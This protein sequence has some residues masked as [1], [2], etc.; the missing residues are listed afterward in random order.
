MENNMPTGL[1]S[2][3]KKLALRRTIQAIVAGGTLSIAAA[4]S[5]TAIDDTIKK[6]TKVGATA[7]T[8]STPSVFN[9]DIRTVSKAPKWQPGDAIKVVNP[10]R[11]RNTPNILPPVNAPQADPLVA[12]QAQ[13]KVDKTV[14]RSATVKVNMDGLGFSGVNPPDPTGDIGLNYYIQSING[15]SGALFSIHDK[16]DGS[17]VADSLSMSDLHTGDCTSTS[18]DPIVL[19]DEQANRWLL[20]EFANQG[21]D[22][23]CVLVSQTDDPVNGGWYAY[24]FQAPSFPDYPKYSQIGGVYYASANENANAVYAFDREKMLVGERTTMVRMEI[25]RLSGFGF[26]SIT[27]IDVD[28]NMPAPAGTPGMFIRHRD[29]ELHNSGSNNPEKDYLEIYTL[30]P[31][32]ESP[33]DSVLIGPTSI[34]VAEF[35]SDFNCAGPGFGCLTQKDSNYTL[36]PLRETVMYKGQYRNF[37]GHESIVGNF[38]TNPGDNVAA[39]RWFELRRVGESDWALHDEGTYSENDGTSRYMGGAVLDKNGNLGLSYM[40]TGADR[41]P[42]IGFNGREASDAAGTLTFGE[43]IL[44][45]GTSS[46]ESDR[47]GDYSQMGIDPVDHCTMWFT[48]EYGKESGV[49]GT[50]IS[51]F[52][53]PSCADPNPG[54][55]IALSDSAQEVCQNGD[56]APMTVSASAYND[57]DDNIMLS[58]SELPEGF[59]GSFSANTFKPGEMVTT[60]VTIA[61]GTAAGRYTFNIDAASGDATP[62]SSSASVNIVGAAATVG[63]SYPENGAEMTSVVPEFSWET[64]GAAKTVKIEIATD[65]EFS[66]IVAMGEVSGGNSYRPSTPLASATQFYWRA[67]AINVCGDTMSEVYSFMTDDETSYATELYNQET[68]APLTL[69]AQEITYYF[70][71]VLPG[72]TDLTISTQGDNG[73]ADLYVSYGAR[74]Q[75]GVSAICESETFTSNEVCE[76]EGEVEPGLYF[77]AVY[78]WG[79][80][81]N[82]T[83]TAGYDDS[84]VVITP[85]IAGQNFVSVDEDSSVELT[86]DAVNVSNIRN[87]STLEMSVSEGDNYTFDGNTIMPAADY[88]GQLMVPVVVSRNDTPSDAFNLYITVVAIN[89]APMAADDSIVL[90]EGNST[91]VQ[92]LANDTDVDEGDTLTITAID[93]AGSGTVAINGDSI[94][95]TPG[96]GFIGDE[97]LTYTIADSAGETSQA[98]VS[99]TVS[100]RPSPTVTGG[101]SSGGGSFSPLFALLLLPLM[102]LRRRKVK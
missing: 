48:S 10:R 72:A 45:E 57:F 29:D 61:E 14:Q 28:G 101:S 94:D 67:T 58:Y 47:N 83:V 7:V 30:A 65:A 81:S 16:K 75:N 89:D 35:S 50:Q 96:S 63:L 97:S 70:I 31:N 5:A 80:F 76:F 95:Y 17:V 32:F 15:R 34:E 3:G 62:R 56:L 13:V 54:F 22:K 24:E 18:G 51:S 23:L 26:N 37:D 38:I 86:V 40:M 66:N 46:I 93:Y 87:T 6:T 68:S 99:I 102:R 9:G 78:A 73:D 55:N 49:W 79:A 25:D 27:P 8:A 100:A 59:S 88:A 91:S 77:A 42:S 98:S 11:I 1:F 33:R 43:T 44:K 12:K 2:P 60:S 53:I 74:V 39:T 82:L 52:D 21:I 84:N 19:F 41:Y 64:G 36:D 20:T 90:A 92:V 4:A 71:E 69:E 85:I